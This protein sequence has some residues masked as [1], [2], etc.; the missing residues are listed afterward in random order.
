MTALVGMDFVV[1]DTEHGPGDQIP[2]SPSPHSRDGGRNSG[3]GAGR[4]RLRDPA[5][6]GSGCRRNHCAARLLG[7]AGGGWSSGRPATLP[8]GTRGFATYTRS[9]RHGLI[10][11]G[12]TPAQRR[13]RERAVILMIE[14]GAGVAAAARIAAVDG[15][16][17][18]FVGPADLSVALGHPGEITGR[19][20]QD[21]IAEVHEAARRADVGGGDASP[22][23]RPRRASNSTAAATWS[24][25]TCWPPSALCSP[26]WPELVRGSGG[27]PRIARNQRARRWCSFPACSGHRGCGTA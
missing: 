18:L 24:S 22:A 15:V 6:T 3:A 27:A 13:D 16:D 9:G 26:G 20:V 2:L 12:G 19:Q 5:G 25:T 11:T 14:D 21:A 10:R 7:R 17:G 23:T 4:K 8:A 1:I